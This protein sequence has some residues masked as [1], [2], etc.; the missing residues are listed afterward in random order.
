[1][2]SSP[3]IILMAGLSCLCKLSHVSN[4]HARNSEPWHLPLE[5]NTLAWEIVAVHKSA[6]YHV[7][8]TCSFCYCECDYSIQKSTDNTWKM[9]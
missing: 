8:G 4:Y 9:L 6:V 7:E 2:H 5:P 3:H 1:M